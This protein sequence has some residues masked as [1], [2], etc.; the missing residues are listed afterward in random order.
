MRPVDITKVSVSSHPLIQATAVSYILIHVKPHTQTHTH[1]H[2]HIQAEDIGKFLWIYLGVR[3]PTE[4]STTYV[5]DSAIYKGGTQMGPA[6]QECL[7]L[8]LPP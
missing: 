3:Q 1:T 4:L 2:T 7:H 6:P 8:P 5:R